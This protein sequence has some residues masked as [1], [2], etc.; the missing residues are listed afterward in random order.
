MSYVV[1]GYGVSFVV[2]AGYAWR[3]LARARALGRTL[4][5]ESWR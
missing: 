3:V 5:P 1:A 2:L 4:P